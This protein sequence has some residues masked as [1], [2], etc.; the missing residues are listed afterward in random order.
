MRHIRWA[1]TRSV[2]YRALSVFLARHSLRRGSRGRIPSNFVPLHTRFYGFRASKELLR[3]LGRA[4]RRQSEGEHHISA[5][6]FLLQVVVTDHLPQSRHIIAASFVDQM[7]PEVMLRGTVDTVVSN[8]GVSSSESA[9]VKCR[10]IGRTLSS[11]PSG[12]S[13]Q[14]RQNAQRHPLLSQMI[15]REPAP[16]A[17]LRASS[18]KKVGY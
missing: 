1:Q 15:G 14:R 16:C 18:L 8:A 2:W 5:V 9:A 13:P 6:G 4:P 11:L 3:D 10:D 7:T 12:S 17:Y